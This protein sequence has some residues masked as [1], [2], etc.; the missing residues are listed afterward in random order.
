MTQRAYR[1]YSEC[2]VPDEDGG[3]DQQLPWP[4]D[5]LSSAKTV[6]EALQKFLQ[7]QKC[8]FC[9]AVISQ[10]DAFCDKCGKSQV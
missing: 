1:R 9:G 2:Y 8:K 7:L 10:R 4:R 5:L 3:A 6:D